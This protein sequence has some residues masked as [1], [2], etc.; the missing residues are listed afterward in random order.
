LKLSPLPERSKSRAI[1]WG[2]VSPT[3][4]DLA[5]HRRPREDSR[6]DRLTRLIRNS[7][8]YRFKLKVGRG[9]AAI[10]FLI[11]VARRMLA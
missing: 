4:C 6:V 7:S 8:S 5:G 10:G 2:Y 1:R 11:N 9:F 3:K